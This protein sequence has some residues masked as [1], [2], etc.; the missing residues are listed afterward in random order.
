MSEVAGLALGAVALVSLFSTCV[1]LM[2]LFELAREQREDL[3]LASLKMGLL[4]M[5]LTSWG[6]G[7]NLDG[8]DTDHEDHVFE[9]YWTRDWNAIGHSLTGI[10]AIFGNA[11]TLSQKY[12]LVPLGQSPHSTSS[13][14][15]PRSKNRWYKRR[16][17]QLESTTLRQKTVWAVRDKKKLD[18]LILDI[19]FLISN[20]EKISW[21]LE[22]SH[23]LGDVERTSQALSVQPP[24]LHIEKVSE[25]TSL[26]AP[27]KQSSKPE[28]CSAEQGKHHGQSSTSSPSTGINATSS[29]N[30][31]S[32]AA[33][34]G[35]IYGTFDIQDCQAQIGN[36]GS[37]ST[38][39]ARHIYD[40]ITLKNSKVIM[41]DAETLA[42]FWNS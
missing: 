6:K 38:S 41:G 2:D 25:H 5:R 7:M 36:S 18:R 16:S 21:R 34:T 35:H 37:T 17:R 19:D 10:H 8:S 30:A 15:S 22:M 1:E 39:G 3:K 29:T 31:Q 42:N 33:T 24:G 23:K 12:E 40:K 28:K 14:V 13:C 9:K 11:S 26:A 27:V 32:I 20:L 4:Q